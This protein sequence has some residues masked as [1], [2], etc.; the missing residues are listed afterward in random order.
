MT[1]PEFK[2]NDLQMSLFNFFK[3]KGFLASVAEK[4]VNNFSAK[5]KSIHNLYYAGVAHTF[6]QIEKIEVFNGTLNDS[7]RQMDYKDFK[8]LTL[9]HFT[10]IKNPLKNLLNDIRNH[11]AHYIHDLSNLNIDSID[12]KL[13][14]FIKDSFRLAMVQTYINER[15]SKEKEL[16]VWTK[17]EKRK[18]IK[19]LLEGEQEIIDF[20]K[21]LFFQ[22]LYVEKKNGKQTFDQET[23]QKREAQKKHID[24]QCSSIPNTIDYILFVHNEDDA[25][26]WVLNKHEANDP[27]D[28]HEHLVLQVAKGTYLSFHA[29][30]FLL[31]MFLYKNEGNYLVPKIS[32]FK[33]NGTKEDQ[34]K[35]EVFLF[36]AKKFSSQDIDSNDKN[37][38]SYR[39]IIQYLNKYP[40]AWNKVLELKNRNQKDD[41]NLIDDLTKTIREWEMER[42]FPLL[43]D[44]A[45]FMQYAYDYFFCARSD[46]NLFKDLIE[47]NPL[48]QEVY[49]E[50]SAYKDDSAY[51][52]NKL[53]KNKPSLLDFIRKYLIK[54]NYVNTNLAQ[55]LTR[56]YINDHQQKKFNEQLLENKKPGKLKRRIALDLFLSSYARN[57]DRFL[58]FAIRYLAETCYFGADAQFKMYKYYT[59]DEQAEAHSK[60]TPKEV[61]KLHFKDS[62]ETCY[63]TYAD[64]LTEYPAWDMPFIME[65]NAVFVRMAAIPQPVCIQRDLMIYFLED[66]LFQ[67]SYPSNGKNLLCAYFPALN[68]SKQAKLATLQ[69]GK[70]IT[71]VEKTEYK[72][73]FPRKLVYNCNPPKGNG[74]KT[75]KKEGGYNAMLENAIKQE[76]RYAKLI[77]QARGNR[78]IDQY[79][80]LQPKTEEE[81]ENAREAFFRERNKGKNFKLRFIRKACNVMYFKD[82]YRSRVTEDLTEHHKSWHIT[83]DEFN[84]F[85]KWMYAFGEVKQYKLYLTTLLEQKGFLGNGEFG[86]IFEASENIEALY[87]KVKTAFA[88][89][90]K[91]YSEREAQ[92]KNTDEADKPKFDNYENLLNNGVRY[93]NLQDFKAFLKEKSALT[94]EDGRVKYYSLKNKEHLNRVFYPATTEKGEVRKFCFDLAKT[95]HEDC[96][97]YEIA[98]RYFNPEQDIA[99]KA[100]KSVRNILTQPIPF[101]QQDIDGK[102][103]TIIVPHKDVEKLRQLQ[104]FEATKPVYA[105]ILLHLPGY[106]EQNQ[107][108]Q[109]LGPIYKRF[110]EDDKKRIALSDLCQVNNHIINQQSRFTQVILI[111]EE[112]FIWKHKLRIPGG[113]NRIQ[114][115]DIPDL[116][117]FMDATA[118]K[119]L[120]NDAFHF[121]LPLEDE[122]YGQVFE[123]IE[124]WFM[125]KEI[126][127][128]EYDKLNNMQKKVLKVFIT[129]M[130]NDRYD[131]RKNYIKGEGGK[132]PDTK[133]VLQE[134]ISDYIK[135]EFF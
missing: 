119:A 29:C 3:N 48:I 14:Q 35:I 49:L 109:A 21:K 38:V 17:E 123:K 84:D 56:V 101:S 19:N 46:N 68:K 54:E 83:R 55:Q 51:R 4:S 62:K 108:A 28:N 15:L 73:L 132:K 1:I 111:L 87:E 2:T 7:T 89:W 127:T 61:D 22:S 107:K 5:E 39:D 103:Y 106:I 66:A 45:G 124:T 10:D 31:S 32:G 33:K 118:G 135:M 40:V 71:D 53:V 57:E 36:Y 131:K 88:K 80:E 82:I 41:Q 97:L 50:L 27:E 67:K 75:N 47:K 6:K 120:R 60:L 90:E 76:D 69:T 117:G 72:K 129:Q 113:S 78:N 95:K 100:K 121:N 134:A 24:N 79:L 18:K 85:C 13:M 59:S 26:N 81:K 92:K 116:G 130:R 52:N 105:K 114:L 12:D 98:L 115:K 8:A 11:S 93:I 37:L 43:K 112:Y 128:K 99:G 70:E 23:K 30:L 77:G 96:L 65:N 64:H 125:K 91:E 25:F 9:E 63:R 34:S 126:D 20:I 44:N 58:H 74:D 86:K 133:K 16:H 102:N 110:T 122:S 104:A 42:Q 94:L